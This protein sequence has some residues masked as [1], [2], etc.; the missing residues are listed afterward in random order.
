MLYVPARVNTAAHHDS[1]LYKEPQYYHYEWYIQRQRMRS[2][3]LRMF[4]P[5]SISYAGRVATTTC[6]IFWT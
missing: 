3:I 6:A 2:Q 4:L 1:A 5:E